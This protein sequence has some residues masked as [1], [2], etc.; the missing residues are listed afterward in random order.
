MNEDKKQAFWNN[1]TETYELL[2]EARN[3]TW[4]KNNITNEVQAQT[5]AKML[6][7]EHAKQSERHMSD[8]LEAERTKNEELRAEIMG[9]RECLDA[10]TETK[11]S[12]APILTP[13]LQ[14]IID[15]HLTPE[16]VMGL[17]VAFSE[18]ERLIWKAVN[19]FHSAVSILAVQ[20]KAN[21]ATFSILEHRV[22]ELCDSL[23]SIS[24]D[25][26]KKVTP[27]LER[28]KQTRK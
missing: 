6:E 3:R 5:I 18:N 2:K 14:H 7:L 25:Q 8:L 4:L 27:I 15:A 26:N 12:P 19:S 24:E 22:R 16:E 1:P 28:I 20:H 11:P 23:K 9:L 13:E 10:I 17:I 21:P